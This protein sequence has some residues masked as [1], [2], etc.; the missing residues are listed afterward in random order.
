MSQDPLTNGDTMSDLILAAIAG[1][2]QDLSEAKKDLRDDLKDVK[3]HLATLNSRTRKAET[4]VAIHWVLW[5]IQG[6]V[7]VMFGEEVVGRVIATIFGG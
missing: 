7:L 6:A 2:K 3:Q 5:V 1:V 4:G